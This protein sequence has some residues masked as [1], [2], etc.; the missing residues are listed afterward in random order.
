MVIHELYLSPVK[1]LLL[2]IPLESAFF[3][4]EATVTA[5]AFRTTS[6]SPLS[7]KSINWAE[8][9]RMPGATLDLSKAIQ[10]FPGVLPKSSFGY[11]ISIRG[12]SSSENI[13]RMDGID[14]PTI[15]H[16]SIQ[17]ASGG[18]VSLINMDFI[19]NVEL[20][21]G[22][23][24]SSMSNVLSGALNIELRNSRTDRFGS[25]VTLGATDYGASLEIPLG[26]KTNLMISGRNSFSQH[27]STFWPYDVI[28]T[29]QNSTFQAFWENS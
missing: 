13:Y 14:I 25:R 2:A 28:L 7:L 5:D 18:A 10:S 9:Q 17:G 8:M 1:P 3:L 23:F 6:E 24:P 4:D 12:G 16:F 11:N 21:S 19:E 26:R 22:A 15:N 27:F 20:Y 29:P